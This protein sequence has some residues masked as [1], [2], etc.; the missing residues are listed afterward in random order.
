MSR[1]SGAG[2]PS[3]GTALRRSSLETVPSLADRENVSRRRRGG[4]ELPSKL[5]Y[6]DFDR[7]GGRTL[8]GVHGRFRVW[9]TSAFASAFA[10]GI[11]RHRVSEKVVAS[12]V[13][14]TV[15]AR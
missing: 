6:M 10:P 2:R 13:P 8:E 11:G 3:L 4:L 15:D 14:E 9:I 12:P 5:R 7:A 1:P